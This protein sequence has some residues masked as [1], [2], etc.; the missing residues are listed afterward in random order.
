MGYQLSW[1]STFRRSKIR[2][3]IKGGFKNTKARNY[4]AAIACFSVA[5]ENIENEDI[6]C[7]NKISSIRHRLD[8]NEEMEAHK[9]HYTYCDSMRA[10][11]YTMLVIIFSDQGN[12]EY[13]NEC[14]NK[15]K[16]VAP[17]EAEKLNASLQT[18]GIEFT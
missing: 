9:E 17:Q 2:T 18:Q 5:L 7:F 4:L 1:R 8:P 16:K 13:A 10:T 14:F 6:F 15:L 3:Q 11:I 12:R